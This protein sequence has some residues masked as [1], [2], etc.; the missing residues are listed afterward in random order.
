MKNIRRADGIYNYSIAAF[1]SGVLGLVAQT[2]LLREDL[3]LYGGNEVALG[4]FLG[5]WLLGVAAGAAASARLGGRAENLVGPLLA[6]QAILLLFS[7]L[8]VRYSR[9]VSGALPFEPF[10]L[11]Q[12]L[13]WTVPA[14][15][16]S[17]FVAGFLFPIL[18]ALARKRGGGVTVLY[19]SE[20]LGSFFGGACA[21]GLLLIGTLPGTIIIGC[22][23]V[24]AF[25]AAILAHRFFRAAFA[26]LGLALLSLS[27]HLGPPLD[28]F[29]NSQ[30][31]S[32]ILPGAELL[33]QVDSP[34]GS[35]TLAMLRGQSA[36]LVDGNIIAAF[37]DVERV[38]RAAGV[39]GAISGGP[40]KILAVG[41]QAIDLLQGLQDFEAVEKIVWVA[42]DPVFKDF[43]LSHVPGLSTD[44]R[45]E[46]L[47]GDPVRIRETLRRKGPFDGIWLLVDTPLRR[48]D[49]RFLT[50][51]TL[52]VLSE[53]LTPGGVMAVPATSAE[54]FVGPRLR[55][56]VGTAVAGM[57]AVFPA[58][59]LTP[60]EDGLVLGAREEGLLSLDS[61]ALRAAY[62]SMRP[63]VDRIPAEGFSTLVDPARL[64]NADALVASLLSDVTVRPSTLDRPLALLNNLIVRAEQENPDLAR[65]IEALRDGTA[66]F[67]APLLVLG[68]FALFGVVAAKNEADRQ[69][70]AA[71]ITLGLGG[72]L[73]M[74]LDLILLHLYQ[75]LFGT[76]YL[77]AGWL[78]GL[79]MIGLASG[80]LGVG[81]LR[82]GA[83]PRLFG[84][85]SLL[86]ISSGA[87]LLAVLG[88]GAMP[89]R[90][91]GSAAFV[92]GG[93]LTG[94]LVPVAESMLSSVGITG[95]GA[96]SAIELADHLGGAVCG[97]LFGIAGIPILGLAGS[98]WLVAGLALFA[99]VAVV[100]SYPKIKFFAAWR[101]PRYESFPYP[102]TA[103]VLLALS[104]AAMVGRMVADRVLSE[105]GT[106]LDEE[107]LVSTGLPTPFRE[108]LLP[109]RHYLAVSEEG[110]VPRGTALASRAAAPGVK[111]YGGR[112][113]LLIA[114][115]HDGRILNAS[116]LDHR[117]TPSYIE[118]IGR[119][120][121]ALEGKSLLEPITLK[122]A[123]TLEEREVSEQEIDAVAGATVTS[124]AVVK[125]LELSGEK[126]AR[127]VF[128]RPYGARSASKGRAI[129]YRLLYMAFSLALVVPVYCFGNRAFRRIWLGFH[130]L[131]GGVWLGVEFSTV[132]I[133]SLLRGD[134]DWNV[135]SWP[136]LLFTGVLVLAI[137]FGPLYCGY[138]CPAGA[139]QE[140]L[141]LLGFSRRLPVGLDRKLRFAKH[142]LLA[143]IVMGALALGVD[144]AD[145]LDLLRQ[146]WTANRTGVG[147]VL[148]VF[149]SVLSLF[150][151]RFGCRYLCPAGAFL[152]LSNKAVFLRGWAPKKRYE[153]CDLGVRS[154]KDV[155]CIQCNRCVLIERAE[156]ASHAGQ[157]LV[158][159][160]LAGALC[161][162]L[163]G[164]I[165]K[166]PE[167]AG[168]V[169]ISVE[170]IDVD[171]IR[172]K[173]RAGRLSDKPA[174]YWHIIGR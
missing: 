55:L 130:A 123:L 63:R 156:K 6:S 99:G 54:N 11:S 66:L 124:E 61:A 59:R 7:T 173:M 169:Q 122:S 145:G 51:E 83:V 64:K 95:L 68:A 84:L 172:K 126:L 125:A 38:Q 134:V 138:L 73:G 76:L 108:E 1:L 26:L 31:L 116:F 80:G 133:L 36:V 60:G 32:T 46:A 47:A 50:V 154:E 132:Q 17:S 92:L 79:W 109:V 102:R 114:T 5:L 78:F 71:M 146:A 48:A 140:L 4:A 9:G 161:L 34:S 41:G 69:K 91:I 62:A 150:S 93:G 42:P 159:L 165:P 18:A 96:G 147:L 65:L 164:A 81:R 105:G 45:L 153:L 30:R 137:L 118:E 72:G 110:G 143:I 128:G 21:T 29:L 90:I 162:M 135:L 85:I 25:G 70:S 141:G 106:K 98:S 170:P 136:G 39:M 53:M 152:N 20:A 103:R 100:L 117:E 13:F 56:S 27:T 2:L 35:L 82:H 104:T 155:E 113:N 166:R 157:K 22:G 119:F 24:G 86:L 33:A 148:I 115:A 15:I 37:P 151:A 52:G 67:L 131:V 142:G 3:A 121:S 8:L 171:L 44:S 12:L 94:A 139:F 120:F 89:N 16:P 158:R 74:A 160:A 163:F 77:E 57:K 28:A 58:V 174:R 144:A 101:V 14:A 75:G 149:V 43:V 10:P 40:R 23:A 129:D 97:L 87:A 88:G 112:I 107:T 168:K 111:G 19:I 49:E 167:G 127:E